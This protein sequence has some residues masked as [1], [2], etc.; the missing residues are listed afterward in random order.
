MV[1]LKNLPPIC[2]KRL[3]SQKFPSQIWC[4]IFGNTYSTCFL[5]KICSIEYKRST[6]LFN[7]F[8]C[9]AI[10]TVYVVLYWLFKFL[11]LGYLIK[12]FVMIITPP[13]LLLINFYLRIRQIYYSLFLT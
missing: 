6:C 8:V 3:V 12:L 13:I 11:K 1:L 7:L 4:R 10:F 2:K 9:I 5:D